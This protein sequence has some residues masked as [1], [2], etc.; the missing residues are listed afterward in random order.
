MLDRA[1]RAVLCDPL[2]RDKLVGEEPAVSHIGHPR[3]PTVC[4]S[5][6]DMSEE[7]EHAAQIE[8]H[9]ILLSVL[10]KAVSSVWKGL[11]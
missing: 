11:E 8:H 9:I 2:A 6:R 4:N 7:Q 1:A 3:S 5:D 10:M